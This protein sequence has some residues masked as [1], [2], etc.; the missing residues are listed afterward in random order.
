MNSSRDELRQMAYDERLYNLYKSLIGL[1]R[2]SRRILKQTMK[3]NERLK[4]L[5]DNAKWKRIK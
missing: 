1:A 3:L 2:K 4:Q 5:E